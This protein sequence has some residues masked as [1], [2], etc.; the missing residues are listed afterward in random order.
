MRFKAKPIGYVGNSFVSHEFCR[1]SDDI[2]SEIHLKRKLSPGL[3]GI[4]D[5]SHIL[6]IFWL[7]RINN[8]EKTAL[9][10]HPRRDHSFPLTGVFATRSPA[11]P[12][13]LGVTVVNLIKRD[14]NVLT[15]KGLDAFDGTP[16]LD[17]KPYFHEDFDITCLKVAE[18]SKKDR[19]ELDTKDT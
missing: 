11:R 19:S 14:K 2:L 16:V 15:V 7:N 9:K 6:V 4:E 13:T 8:R 3:D 18:W 17:I 12:N 10:V 5:F 1:K